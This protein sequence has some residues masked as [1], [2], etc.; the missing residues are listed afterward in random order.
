M[1]PLP[2]DKQQE[3]AS[4]RRQEWATLAL[5]ASVI[6]VL[7]GVVGNSQALSAIWLKSLWAL[8]PP[9]AFLIAVA[10]ER[11][12]A[13]RRFPFGFYR[14]VSIGFLTSALSLV[15]MGVYLL[16]AGLQSH[17]VHAP[18]KLP[19]IGQN[20]AWW[21][22][23]GWW[24]IAALAYSL[25]V[26][27]LIGRRRMTHARNLHDKGLY[28]DAS[29]GKVN[30]LAAATALVGVVGIGIGAPALDIAAT[31]V[32]GAGI[33]TQGTVHLYTAVCD[34]MDE[35]PRTL[36]T[37]RLDPLAENI[38][39]RLTEAP[40]VATARVRLREEGRMLTGIGLVELDTATT[41]VD[42]LARLR[43]VIL[44]L[45]WRLIDFQI[46]PTTAR[47]ATGRATIA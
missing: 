39:R 46:A 32:I 11:R 47:A 15:A 22:W 12:P 9:A 24:V 4:A 34:L 6:A 38:R 33:F 28:A 37:N 36:G 2:A 19:A 44:A 41:E 27:L 7:Y 42:D 20:A 5:R 8:W 31:L 45:D 14:A 13:S 26:P 17:V 16:V 10:L 21:Q 25:A 23:L 35:M 43:D 18:D 1:R 40:G 3:L 29:M 30:A